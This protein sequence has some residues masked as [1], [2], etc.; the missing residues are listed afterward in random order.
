M[1][2]LQDL[3]RRRPQWK[4]HVR[5]GVGSEQRV[6]LPV[7]REEHDRVLVRVFARQ[8]RGRRARGR[9]CAG[10]RAGRP[11]PPARERCA[12]RAPVPHARAQPRRGSRP[13]SSGS[14]TKPTELESRPPPRR[15]RDRAAGCVSDD[16]SPTAGPRGVRAA[17]RRPP[18]AGPRPRT[19]L[20]LATWSRI[21]VSLADVEHDDAKAGRRR[22]GMRRSQPPADEDDDQHRRQ[23]GG[24]P[25]SWRAEASRAGGRA[26][27]A[28]RGRRATSTR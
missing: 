1:R 24:P 11:R 19:R 15:R 17:R 6:E 28:R 12:L 13:A 20:P 21:R 18:P 4:R 8:P 9:G 23:Y 5:L 16:A 27:R 3:D 10:A 22:R 25:A 2:D 14:R 26:R 7:T